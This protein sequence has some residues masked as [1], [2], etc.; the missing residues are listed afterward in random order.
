VKRIV[1]EAIGGWRIAAAGVGYSGF[2]ETILGP[3]NNS[4]SYGNSRP[5]QYRKLEPVLTTVCAPSGHRRRMPLERGAMATH[6]ARI[7]QR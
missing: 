7:P 4:N 3:G 2:P 1:D 5:H 6:A